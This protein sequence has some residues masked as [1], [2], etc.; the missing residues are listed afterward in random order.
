MNQM[1]NV[2]NVDDVADVALPQPY[3]NKSKTNSHGTP[4]YIIENL[5]KQYDGKLSAFDPC[6][7]NDNP[8][9]DGT[10]LD[11][12]EHVTPGEVVFVN[13]PFS[14]LKTTKARKGWVDK[15]CEEAVTNSIKIVALLPARVDTQWFHDVILKHGSV[16]FIRGR[17]T[18]KG[19]TAPAPFPCMYW[20]LN[21]GDVADVGSEVEDV[22]D[23]TLCDCAVK[24]GGKPHARGFMAHGIALEAAGMVWKTPPGGHPGGGGEWVKATADVAPTQKKKILPKKVKKIT[25]DTIMKGVVCCKCG[26]VLPPHTCEQHLN[27]KFMQA[28]H[29]PQDCDQVTHIKN[30]ME[31]DGDDWT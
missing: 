6:P 26:G 28:L 3:M 23:V 7:L 25:A 10:A 21:C 22:A 16:E 4:D 27:L 1:S 8:T 12:G 19:S 14:Q 2:A 20:R 13:P 5:N 15:M 18:F 31:R 30:K 11:W 9:F 24:H 17:I 29:T